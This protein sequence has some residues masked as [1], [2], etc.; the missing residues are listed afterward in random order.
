MET[1]TSDTF[2]LWR[3]EGR[4]LIPQHF[5]VFRHLVTQA[6]H[7]VEQDKYD[8]AAIY[9]AIAAEYACGK[10]SGLFVSSELEQVLMTIGQRAI[11]TSI[12]HHQSVSRSKQPRNILHVATSVMSIGGLSRMM[13]RWIKQDNERS[14]SLVLTRHLGNKVPNILRDAI[15]NSQGKIYFL[16]ESI[17]SII[18]WSKRLRE[19]ALEADLVVLHIFNQD[20]IPIIAFANAQESPPIIYLNHADH[21]FWV[22]VGISNV[23]VDLR[24]SGMRLS[25]ER[26]GV[27]GKRN[28]LLPIILE[29]TQR[30]LSRAEAKQQIGIPQD[31]VLIL[32]IARSLKYKTIDGI[33]FADTHIPLLKQYKQ[34]ILLVIGAGNR[35]DWS[36]AIQQTEGRIRVLSET[37]NTAI[38]YQAADIYVDSF[39]FV[40]N[41]SLLEAGSYGVPLVSRYPYSSEACSIL[42]TDMP[43]LNGNLIQVQ[44]IDEYTSVLSRLVEDED[45]RLSLGEA[46]RSKISETHWGNNLQHFLNDIYYNAATMPRP[47]INSNVTDEMFIGE[48]DVFLPKIHGTDIN[49]KKL[50]QW[51]IKFMPLPE[52]FYYWLKFLKKHGLH[53]NPIKLLVP[54]WISYHYRLLRSFVGLK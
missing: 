30:L 45:Y 36:S 26:R 12:D 41:T 22:G 21:L 16:N 1:L 5:E 43:G 19:I 32:S 27:E 47:T 13:W 34:A 6:K 54:E 15:S 53:N 3:E 51:Y 23:V 44:D 46:T 28:L 38:F 48:P 9:G 42:G 31:C 29:P 50:V 4:Q 14:H 11:S 40:S 7:F 37:D 17:G 52:R 8:M 2:N 24:D 20:V 39:P 49:I 33:N 25:Q 35:E 10:H 18:S